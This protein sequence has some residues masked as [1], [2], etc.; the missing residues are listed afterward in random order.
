VRVVSKLRVTLF[1]LPFSPR[2]LVDGFEREDSRCP[3][4][5]SQTYGSP[6]SLFS[7]SSLLGP[8]LVNLG[9]V[10]TRE[11]ITEF[12]PNWFF[13]ILLFS[14]SLFFLFLL[15]PDG[16]HSPEDPIAQARAARRRSGVIA[17][18]ASLSFSSSLLFF[19]SLSPFF[20]LLDESAAGPVARGILRAE[21]L[22]NLRFRARRQK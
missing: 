21:G 4:R 7:F 3:N 2:D 9:S 1:P 18:C 19:S 6:S 16:R 22:R 15:A 10:R 5:K 8:G 12:G 13:T 11:K 14:L 17:A 20:F